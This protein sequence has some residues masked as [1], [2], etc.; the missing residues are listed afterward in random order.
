MRASGLPIFKIE[1]EKGREQHEVSLTHTPDIA[2]IVSDTN[3]LKALITSLAE[4]HGMRADFSAKPL[5]GEPGSGLHIHVHLENA[6]GKNLFYKDDAEIS[7]LL[8][9]SIGGLLA[10]MREDMGIFAPTD[11]SR[12][13]FAPGSNAPTTISWGANNRTCAVRL[14][15]K[16][17]DN[18]HIEHR[19]A[20]AD[21]DVS[22]VI[23]AVLN[24]MAYGIANEIMPPAQIYGDA[25]LAMYGLPKLIEQ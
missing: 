7:D 25:S 17:C 12:K 4:K 10:K 1:K 11:A 18:K 24:A 20:G 16:S 3:Q 23:D 13:R 5:A 22:A 6:E 14:P 19:V 8:A 21:A 15:D 9:Y 2:Q